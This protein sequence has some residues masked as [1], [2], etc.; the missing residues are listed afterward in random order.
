MRRL[1][2]KICGMSEAGN[3]K[4]VGDLLPDYLGFIF[5]APS[6][7][8]AFNLRPSDLSCL[9]PSIEKIAVFVDEDSRTMHTILRKYKIQTVQLHGRESVESCATLKEKGYK[10]I[11]VLSGNQLPP[12]SE[13][14][15]YASVVDHF[16][17]DHRTLGLPGGSGKSFQ[18]ENTVSREFYGSFILSGGL[19]QQKVLSLIKDPPENIFA[20]DV[21]S[22]F[23]TRPGIKDISKLKTIMT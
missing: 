5:Y 15:A 7:R 16:L 18:Y 13:I 1:Q 4:A 12:Q 23:E 19:D 21:N 22:H 10:L 3:L 14:E 11:K 2:L 17:L 8:N 9:D 20:I 6:P